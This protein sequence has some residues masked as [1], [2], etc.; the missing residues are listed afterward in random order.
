MKRVVSKGR[1]EGVLTGL[2]TA[3]ELTHAFFGTVSHQIRTWLFRA[4]GSLSRTR[5]RRIVSLFLDGATK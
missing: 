5:A 4:E 3:D 2:Y 1:K